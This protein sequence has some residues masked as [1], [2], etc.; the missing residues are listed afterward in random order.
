MWDENHLTCVKLH[1]F[2]HLIIIYY[3]L[4]NLWLLL[5]QIKDKLLKAVDESK[6]YVMKSFEEK[7]A[8]LRPNWYSSLDLPTWQKDHPAMSWDFPKEAVPVV[9][10]LGKLL[11]QI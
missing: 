10:S 2:Q 11:H 4:T 7:E 3:H 5:L 1:L 8:R 9:A 6:K